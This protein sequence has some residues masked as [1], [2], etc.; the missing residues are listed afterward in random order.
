MSKASERR[1]A[2]LNFFSEKNISTDNVNV[3]EAENVAANEVVAILPK[4]KE[5]S[6]LLLPFF[7][8]FVIFFR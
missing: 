6:F 3:D 5:K 2:L 4:G 7:H 1:K 8:H